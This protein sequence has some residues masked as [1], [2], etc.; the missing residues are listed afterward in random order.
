MDASRE[1]LI[2]LTG[3]GSMPP[4][5]AVR[6]SAATLLLWSVLGCGLPSCATPWFFGK[7]QE[8]GEVSE[9]VE[10]TFDGVKLVGELA[11]PEGLSYQRVEAVGLVTNLRGTGSDPPPSPMREEL[12]KE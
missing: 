5:I 9:L 2:L 8:K 12:K 1:M 3:V 4:T 6:R 11:S 7:D 10:E